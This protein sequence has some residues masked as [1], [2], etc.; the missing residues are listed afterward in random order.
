MS[1]LSA[2]AVA[3]QANKQLQ[4]TGSRL[5]YQLREEGEKRGRGRGVGPRMQVFAQATSQLGGSGE[6]QA[7]I[8]GA[9]SGCNRKE[10][11]RRKQRLPWSSLVATATLNNSGMSNDEVNCEFKDF[12]SGPDLTFLRHSAVR[13]SIFRGSLSV[14]ENILPS[15]WSV[16]RR[17]EDIDYQNIMKRR[18]HRCR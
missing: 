1:R 14:H 5:N 7:A 3:P 2:G 15:P 8:C 17:G 16:P 9:I 13:N 6:G 11:N 12:S 10:K 18:W 4:G